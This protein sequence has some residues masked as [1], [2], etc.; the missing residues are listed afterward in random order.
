MRSHPAPSEAT[1]SSCEVVRNRDSPSGKSV[2]VGSAVFRYSTPRASSSS[3]SSAYAADPVKSGC[4]AANTSWVKPGSVMSAVR[5]A[6][7]SQS[8]RSSTQTFHPRRA[9]RAP[10]TSALIPLPTATAS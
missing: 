7:P 5:I 8:L 10:A 1:F 2:A 4:H 6:P 9:N 3:R